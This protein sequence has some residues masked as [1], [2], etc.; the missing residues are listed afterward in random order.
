MTRRESLRA[1]GFAFLLLTA[2][3]VWLLGPWGLLAAGIVLAAAV[4]FGFNEVSE[5]ER[6][7]AVGDAPS[8]FRGRHREPLQHGAVPR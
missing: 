7:E 2:A 6:G 5:A 8:P 4:L 3:L 1:L